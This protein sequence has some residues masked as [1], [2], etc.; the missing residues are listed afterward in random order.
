ML[1]LYGDKIFDELELVQTAIAKVSN[2][3]A[4]D[5]NSMERERHR[6]LSIDNLRMSSSIRKRQDVPPWVQVGS[7]NDLEKLQRQ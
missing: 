6:S 7:I 3:S 4:S 5:D 2:P 1:V